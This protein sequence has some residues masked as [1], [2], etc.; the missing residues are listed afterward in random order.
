MAKHKEI[1]QKFHLDLLELI[2]SNQFERKG[3][4]NLCSKTQKDACKDI[5][6]KRLQINS[7]QNQRTLIVACIIQ[8]PNRKIKINWERI[9]LF[10]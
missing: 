10:S 9:N 7:F 6:S 2:I 8:N 3:V 5:S 1:V 4:L